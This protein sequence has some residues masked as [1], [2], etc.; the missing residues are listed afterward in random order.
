MPN[1]YI[2]DFSNE[3][4]EI[5]AFNRPLNIEKEPT[6]LPMIEE[7]QRP[8]LQQLLN[9][10]RSLASAQSQIPQQSI[11]EP[12]TPTIEDLISQQT[13]VS[14]PPSMAQDLPQSQKINDEL[15]AALDRRNDMQFHG[16]ILS[17]IQDVIKGATGAD[18]NYSTAKNLREQGQQELTDHLKGTELQAANRKENRDIEA[19]KLNQEQMQQSINSTEQKFKAMGIDLQNKEALQDPNNRT[20]PIIKNAIQNKLDKYAMQNKLPR[21]VIPDGL[22]LVELNNIDDF[23]GKGMG[24]LTAYQQA[25]LAQ[26]GRRLK[27]DERQAD[28]R[29]TQEKRRIGSFEKSYRDKMTS[30]ERFKNFEK[31][32]QAFQQLPALIDAAKQGNQA[33]VSSLG[34]RMA[35]GMGEVGALS[36]GDVTRYLGNQSYSRQ[37]KDWVSRRLQGK[38]PNESAADLIA[39]AEIMQDQVNTHIIPIYSEYASSMINTHPNELSIDDALK[40]LGAPGYVSPEIGKKIETKVA[41]QK[42]DAKKEAKEGSAKAAPVETDFVTMISPDGEQQRVHK[43]QVDKYLKKGAKLAK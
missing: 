10:Y 8:D 11:V 38:I 7:P 37:V 16:N 15:R 13:S 40:K 28:Q 31:Q 30:D 27:L 35:K 34:T 22:N 24:D 39:V 5:N 36:E 21:G 1:R 14:Q 19:F 6:E 33:A 23:V 9:Q 12:Q 2:E 3:P 43:D 20:I 17:G 32:E 29:D 26:S 18:V 4:Q 41:E 25:Q 42:A